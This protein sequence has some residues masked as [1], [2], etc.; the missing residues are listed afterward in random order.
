MH[1]EKTEKGR[2]HLPRL[3]RRKRA[4]ALAKKMGVQE[5]HEP[6]AYSGIFTA[7]V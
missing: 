6:A 3:R 5:L 4:D 1:E 7:G 2:E